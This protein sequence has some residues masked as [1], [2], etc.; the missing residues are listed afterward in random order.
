MTRLAI[1]RA[2][3]LSRPPRT[4]QRRVLVPAALALGLLVWSC[5]A[6]SAAPI[7]GFDFTQLPPLRLQM[8]SA[9]TRQPIQTSR[10][11]VERFD[12]D[13]ARLLAVHA[14]TARPANATMESRMLLSAGASMRCLEEEHRVRTADGETVA[15]SV[16]QFRPEALS[17]PGQSVPDDTYSITEGMLYLLGH[18]PLDRDG[19]A[20]FHVLGVSQAFRLNLRKHGSEEIT[21]PA[22]RFACDHVRMRI[23]AESLGLPAVLR[24]FARLFLPELEAWIARDPPHLTVRLSGPFGPPDD[25]DV[26]IELT[27]IEAPR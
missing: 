19:D 26:L 7:Q 9:R 4:L 18:V 2:I 15:L 17:F 6:A 5:T 23:D 22:G 10:L 12:R 13:G 27:E 20:S 14:A 21:V 24:P 1:R 16:R 25:R 11:W 3:E 8:V